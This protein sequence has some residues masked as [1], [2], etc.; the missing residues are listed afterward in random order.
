MPES[1]GRKKSRSS[2]RAPGSQYLGGS[3]TSTRST[4]RIKRW[5]A[6]IA[7]VLVAVAV[8]AGFALSGFVG[9]G[10]PD[11]SIANSNTGEPIG[12]QKD[13][14]PMLF[15][16]S[17]HF[18]IGNEFDAYNTSPPTSGPHWASGWAQCG[19][20]S[21]ENDVPDER[22]VHNLEHGQVVISHNL[23]TD[24][25]IEELKKIVRALPD[26]RSWMIMRPYSALPEDQIVVHSWGWLQRFAKIDQPGILAFY[27]AHIN[28]GPESINC[29]T[30]GT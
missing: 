10:N 11:P 12:E 25:Q 18:A 26:R 5:L 14:M 3:P 2:E 20:Y 8:I 9:T 24:S 17:N 4:R 16:P 30:G 19:I 7:V 23:S 13:L 27:T 29:L 6:Y 1:K 15:P 22:I 28:R 21:N